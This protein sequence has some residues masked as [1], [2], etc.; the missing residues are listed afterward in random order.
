MT[1]TL[2][3]Q[4]QKYCT[5]LHLAVH[6]QPTSFTRHGAIQTSCV[7][8][9][10]FA[11]C[12]LWSHSFGV[13]SLFDFSLV[14]CWKI[15]CPKCRKPTWAGCGRHIESAL[16]GAKHTVE[17]TCIPWYL[18]LE[19]VCSGVDAAS[20]HARTTQ[21]HARLAS[22]GIAVADRCAAWKAGGCQ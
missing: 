22:T 16:R 14:M 3:C 15:D 7:P 9:T 11:T 5:S 2:S 21:R 1:C 4:P 17:R 18:T 19:R 12:S 10:W 20:R 8:P 6:P 13:M